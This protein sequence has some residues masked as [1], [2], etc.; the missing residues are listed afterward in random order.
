MVVGQVLA[1][2]SPKVPVVQD[3]RVV[4]QLAPNRPHEALGHPVLPGALVAR[5]RGLERHR[6]DRCDHLRREDRVPVEHQIPRTATGLV[7]GERLP[8]LLDLCLATTR[9]AVLVTGREGSCGARGARGAQVLGMRAHP[10]CPVRP[11]L[12]DRNRCPGVLGGLLRGPPTLPWPTRTGGGGRRPAV[13]R[14]LRRHLQGGVPR[15]EPPARPSRPRDDEYLAY[16]H[17]DRTHAEHPPKMSAV[18]NNDVVKQV[19]PNRPHESLGHSVVARTGGEGDGAGLEPTSRNREMD[20]GHADRRQQ[21]ARQRPGP[22]SWV[23]AA[24]PAAA[25]RPR[26]RRGRRGG[27]G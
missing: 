27:C 18:E 24:D 14:G 9:S 10:G 8:Q 13:G 25:R 16:Y 15:D 1:E 26:A 6:S 7:K 2:Q 22:G 21:Q 17:G 5:T 11:T 23:R 19:A 4:E 12:A 20:R 3:D